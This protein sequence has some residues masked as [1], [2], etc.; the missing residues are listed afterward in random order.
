M[1]YINYISKDGIIP[2]KV[3]TN[4]ET[5]KTP[6]FSRSLSLSPPLIVILHALA[7]CFFSDIRAHREAGLEDVGDAEKGEHCLMAAGEGW[8]ME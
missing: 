7:P 2:P 1:L 8:E 3:K 6:W 4:K 5:N